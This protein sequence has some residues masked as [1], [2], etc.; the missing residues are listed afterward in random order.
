MFI[1]YEK[2]IHS[3]FCGGGTESIISDESRIILAHVRAWDDGSV[4]ENFS[5]PLKGERLSRRGRGWRKV[6]GER[7]LM[8]QEWAWEVT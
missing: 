7:L 1:I 3:P 4:I 5:A 6:T 2:K 8:A